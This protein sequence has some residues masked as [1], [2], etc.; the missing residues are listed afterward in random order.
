MQ[1]AE[2]ILTNSK[3]II[4]DLYHDHHHPCDLLISEARRRMDDEELR[5]SRLAKLQREALAS[6]KANAAIEMKWGERRIVSM[7]HDL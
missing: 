3:T 7:I 5:R 1:H 6:A 4:L 2:Y